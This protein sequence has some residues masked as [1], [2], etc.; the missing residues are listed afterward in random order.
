MRISDWSSDVC[1]SDLLVDR[2]VA[3]LRH[4][5]VAAALGDQLRY[6]GLG[7]AEIAEMP[8]RGR[9]GRDAGGYRSGERRVG[10]GGVVGG[11]FGGGRILKK[12][13]TQQTQ[14]VQTRHNSAKR[15]YNT[16]TDI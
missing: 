13:N 11:N 14:T 15:Y 8:G 6:V 7:V 10:E 3:H 12:K 16:S 9:A 5:V 1:S 4:Q 2:P